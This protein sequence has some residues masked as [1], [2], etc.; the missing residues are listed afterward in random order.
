MSDLPIGAKLFITNQR[1]KEDDSDTESESRVPR[2]PGYLL[3]IRT[4]SLAMNDFI[5]RWCA[6]ISAHEVYVSS[7]NGSY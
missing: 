3:G 2:P 1:S 7:L 6:A 5:E 4:N